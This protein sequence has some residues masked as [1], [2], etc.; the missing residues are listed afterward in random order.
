MHTYIIYN[1][2][3]YIL[4][5]IYINIYNFLFLYIY[6]YIYICISL[7]IYMYIYIFSAAR[8]AAKHVKTN[9]MSTTVGTTQRNATS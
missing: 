2:S 6:I 1:F 4:Y 5:F 8:N 9:P 3:L 7:C